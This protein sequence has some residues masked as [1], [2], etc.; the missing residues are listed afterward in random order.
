MKRHWLFQIAN[1]QFQAVYGRR[2]FSVNNNCFVKAKHISSYSLRTYKPSTQNVFSEHCVCDEFELFAKFDEESSGRLGETR[3][4]KYPH[5][6][7]AS[8]GVILAM[9]HTDRECEPRVYKHR[10]PNHTRR[11]AALSL[12]SSHRVGDSRLYIYPKK[13]RATQGQTAPAHAAN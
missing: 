13:L 3:L 10:N 2:V 6:N 9:K 5:T 12:E 8:M 1:Q 11:E 4:Y 7:Q